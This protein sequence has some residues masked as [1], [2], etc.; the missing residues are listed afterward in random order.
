MRKNRKIM[1]G[2]A[3]KNTA[4]NNLVKTAQSRFPS[5]NWGGGAVNHYFVIYRALNRF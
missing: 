3:D 2:K 5:G 1:T 4:K